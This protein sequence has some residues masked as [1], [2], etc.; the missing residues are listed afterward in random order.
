LEVTL[1]DAATSLGGQETTWD[2]IRNG[3]S[4][5][6]QGLR[7]SMQ[8]IVIGLC[9]VAPWAVAIWIGWRLF[10]R[11]KERRPADAPTSR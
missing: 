9:F 10:Q 7:W 1:A 11:G 8:M 4:V 2:A 5:S 3:L 6:G